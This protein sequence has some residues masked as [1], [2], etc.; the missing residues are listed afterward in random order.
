[1]LFLISIYFAAQ[2][3]NQLQVFKLV[4]VFTQGDEEMLLNMLKLCP[5]LTDTA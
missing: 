5:S 4:K 3:Q 1:M 2:I